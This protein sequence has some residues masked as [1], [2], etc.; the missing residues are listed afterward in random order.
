M[1]TRNQNTYDIRDQV[2]GRTQPNQVQ[3]QS[4]LTKYGIDYSPE[5]QAQ[6]A[7]IFRG[8]AT[9]DYNLAR[10]Q[11]SRDSA[12]QQSTLRDDIRRSQAEAVATGASR[13]MQAANE[14]SAMLGLQQATSQG[15]T[16]LQGNYANALS[17]AQVDAANIQTQRAQVGSE[18]GAA[19][20]AANAQR[21]A[22][23]TD[24][25]SNDFMRALSNAAAA[26]ES[27][28]TELARMLIQSATGAWDP[29]SASQA[30]GGVVDQATID[31]NNTATWTPASTSK[32]RLNV[33][34]DNFS[35]TFD[36]TKYGNLEIGTN[37]PEKITSN[38]QVQAIP[39][40]TMFI[41]D[42]V[43][44]IKHAEGVRRVG[45]T[46]K[47]GADNTGKGKGTSSYNNLYTALEAKGMV[48]K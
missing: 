3:Q 46:G 48:I 14:L 39:N 29:E 44:Y 10:N 16:E 18:I 7:D 27:G 45:G 42:G 34:G 23:D 12:Q 47:S 41:A 5:Q 22:A 30:A 28:D 36:G 17:Q 2:A 24:F 13:G 19:D 38:K 26:M 15:A 37:A 20:I 11:F 32:A 40:S 33:K 4:D 43:I 21:Y 35:A 1:A 25:A 9:S 31:P 6:I 8:A